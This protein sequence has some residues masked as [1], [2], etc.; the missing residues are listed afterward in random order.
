[1]TRAGAPAGLPGRGRPVSGR[2]LRLAC[3]LAGERFEAEILPGG[4]DWQL[5]RPGRRHRDRHPLLRADLR[6]EVSPVLPDVGVRSGPPDRVL[7]ALLRG[8]A[9]D[10]ASYYFRVAVYLET[11]APRLA[12]LERSVFVASAAPRRGQRVVYRLPGDL[13]PPWRAAPG[14]ARGRGPGRTPA[15]R[16]RTARRPA[17]PG[18]STAAA[19]RRSPG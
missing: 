16:S 12:A 6:R 18:R 13:R 3:G 14:P 9:V 11:S 10:P 7:A 15:A 1:M 8:E 4:S 17:A 5:V 19:R 2:R